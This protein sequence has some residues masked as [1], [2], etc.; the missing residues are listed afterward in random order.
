MDIDHD[1][2][3]ESCMRL[4][5]AGIMIVAAWS[6]FTIQ[7][8]YYK[9]DLLRMCL[10]LKNINRTVRRYTAQVEILAD[11][12]DHKVIRQLI[13]ADSRV[14]SGDNSYWHLLWRNLDIRGKSKYKTN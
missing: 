5:T 9:Q 3:S 8:L 2:S 14:N 7:R 4:R 12:K 10:S 11:S 13:S 1:F 6:E